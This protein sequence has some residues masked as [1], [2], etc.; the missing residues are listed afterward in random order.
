MDGMI[1]KADLMGAMMYSKKIVLDS[2][3][4]A[5]VDDGCVFDTINAYEKCLDRILGLGIGYD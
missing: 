4:K 1:N 3:H 2:A 5:H